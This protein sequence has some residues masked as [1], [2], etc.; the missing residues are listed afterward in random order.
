MLVFFRAW[1]WHCCILQEMLGPGELYVGVDLV[2]I[3][4]MLFL[5][6]QMDPAK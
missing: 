2:G 6:A 1:E 3:S 5:G 4:S